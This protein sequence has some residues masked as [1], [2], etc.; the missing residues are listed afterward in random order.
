TKTWTECRNF[1]LPM[2]PQRTELEFAVK[3]VLT[4]LGIHGK[5]VQRRKKGRSTQEKN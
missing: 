1:V 4:E 2:N 5:I 3:A